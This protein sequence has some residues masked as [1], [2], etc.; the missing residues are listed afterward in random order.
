[1]WIGFVVVLF[2]SWWLLDLPQKEELLPLIS[3]YFVAYGL[4][5]VFLAALLESTLVI[6]WYFPGGVVMFLCVAISPTPLQ[7]ATVVLTIMGG[8]YVGYTINFLVGKYGWYRLLLKFGIRRQL[9][10]AQANLL[11]NGPRA[12]LA[13]YWMPGLGAIVATA[14]GVL[15]YELKKFLQWSLVSTVAWS[16]FI[17][18]TVY[19]LG[20][21]ALSSLL[22]PVIIVAFIVA[23]GLLRFANTYFEERKKPK[24]AL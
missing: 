11:K 23:W 19:V 8:L 2:G 5:I 13:S 14:A 20:E 4:V 24:D 15:Q 1:M 9:E 17:G 18:T 12:I 22:N 3:H 6:G 16:T 10:E 21:R 7:A